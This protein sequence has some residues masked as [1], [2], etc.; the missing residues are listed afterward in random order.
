MTQANPFMWRAI[1]LVMAFV[2]A[3][4]TPSL[5]SQAPSPEIYFLR[6]TLAPVVN[7]RPLQ[8]QILPVRTRPGYASDAILRIGPERTLDIFAASRWPDV[9]PRVVEGLLVDGL[10]SAGVG[11]VLEPL[12]SGRADR[13]V[14]VVVRRFDADYSQ[15]PRQP[16]VHVSWDVMVLDRVRRDVVMSFTVESMVPAT[17]NRMG[18]IIAAF[19]QASADA[20]GQTA[21]RLADD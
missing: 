3:A 18:S 10:K 1:S 16:R 9:L 11:Q 14:Q 19:E 12:S 15:T 8:L 17:E 7:E 6:P 21:Q 13:L 2:L 5:Q 20:L 4:C